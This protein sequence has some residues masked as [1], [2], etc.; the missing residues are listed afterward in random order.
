[1]IPPPRCPRPS[2]IFIPEYKASMVGLRAFRRPV[3]YLPWRWQKPAGVFADL[4]NIDAEHPTARRRL[5]GVGRM[6]RRIALNGLNFF[7]AAV[8]AGF[9][10]FVA[11]WLTQQG[12]SQASLG[13][14]LSV[15]TLAGLAGQVPGGMLVDHLHTKRFVAA[16]AV[17]VMGLAAIAL[18]VS[19]SVPVVWGAEIGNVLASCVMTPAIAALTLVAVRTCRVQRASWSQHPLRRS[20]Q[21]DF[22]CPAGRCC[23][24]YVGTFGIPGECGVGDPRGGRG[25]S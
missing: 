23:R 4:Q 7:T 17:L 16:G 10:A 8:Q 24:L 5:L 9:G 6:R 19:A 12:W 25:C 14:A 15:G 22:G 3:L 13:V 18:G 20:W 2:T 11:V 1:M 21:H